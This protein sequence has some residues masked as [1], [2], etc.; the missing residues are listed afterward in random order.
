MNEI[1]FARTSPVNKLQIVERLQK[2]GEIVAMTGGNLG[3]L[4]DG[5]FA[6]FAMQME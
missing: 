5:V 6:D 4:H 2:T 3:R 1:V